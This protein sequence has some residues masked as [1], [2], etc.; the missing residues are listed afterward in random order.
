[1]GLNNFNPR[2][3]R[4]MFDTHYFPDG[5]IIAH[6]ALCASRH[7]IPAAIDGAIFPQSVDPVDVQA[8]QRH[9]DAIIK[10]SRVNDLTVYVTGLTMA[11]VAVINTCLACGIVLHLMHYDRE[12][13][14][15][16]SQD[17]RTCEQE[18]GEYV[19]SL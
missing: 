16:F 2:P 9:A 15:Y 10:A 14:E 19:E 5:R 3:T 11:L 17:V 13:G 8:A 4:R 1:M 7:E 12:T 18:G 6:V